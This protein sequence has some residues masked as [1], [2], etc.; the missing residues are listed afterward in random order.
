MTALP[1]LVAGFHSLVGLSAVFVAIA[2]Y[3]SPETYGIGTAGNIHGGSLLEMSLG[4][5]IGAITFTGS[6]VA[7]AKLQGLVSGKPLQFKGQHAL[8][9]GLGVV[10]LAL[11]ILLSTTQM[12]GSFWLIVLIALAL[13]F[14]LILPIGG[15][16][17][18]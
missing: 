8:N 18:R 10:V 5:A 4:V 9:A 15:R 6:L 12:P 14:L 11:I 1:Q 13:G 2:A 7:F 16:I 17:C 3:T